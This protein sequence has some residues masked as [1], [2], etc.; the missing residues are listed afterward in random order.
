MVF[1]LPRLPFNWNTQP[2]LFERYWD[3]FANQLE[4]TLNTILDIPII[5]AAV[6]AAQ[7]SATAAAGSA[8][9]AQTAA[10]GAQA[11]ADIQRAKSS[12]IDSYCSFTPPLLTAAVG[13]TV[14]VANHTR[15]YGDTVLNPSRAVTGAA[16]ATGAAAASIV[17]IYYN[18]ST[19]VGGAVTYLFTVDPATPPV[20]G[21]VLHSVGVVTIPAAGVN[22]GK[23]LNPPGYIEP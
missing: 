13:G 3:E 21:G 14:T 5:Q 2:Q 20:Q 17:R 1:K 11:A 19:R 16:V 8:S 18:D 10:N 9:T 22:D 7:A 15:V 4:K 6:A 23:G 12:L